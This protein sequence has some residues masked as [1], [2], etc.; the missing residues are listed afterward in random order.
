MNYFIYTSQH[1]YYF[2]KKCGHKPKRLY[3]SVLHAPK[4]SLKTKEKTEANDFVSMLSVKTCTSCKKEIVLTKTTPCLKHILKVSSEY[5]MCACCL[6]EIS[7]GNIQEINSDMYEC[8][9]DTEDNSAKYDLGQNYICTEC[10]PQYLKTIKIE[11]SG[12]EIQSKYENTQPT[13]SQSSAETPQIT[14]PFSEF[15]SGS[16]CNREESVFLDYE[17]ISNTFL[18]LS[19]T[20]FAPWEVYLQHGKTGVKL[21]FYLESSSES[22]PTKKLTLFC[23]F[24]F[25]AP[26][27]V[28][29]SVYALGK[30]VDSGFLPM[31]I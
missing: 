27:Q 29:F 8:F 3:S 10:S 16:A 5:Y 13:G 9:S 31:T 12:T 22:L 14:F 19:K 20:Q 7:N 17:V 28:S 18:L 15:F 25:G 1:H 4:T 2:Q 21:H 24:L 30:Q 26:Y 6:D 23:P 11:K